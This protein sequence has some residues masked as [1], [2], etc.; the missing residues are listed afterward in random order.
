[1]LDL[2]GGRLPIQTVPRAGNDVESSAHVLPAAE[3]LERN[4]LVTWEVFS[5]GAI[6]E[7]STGGTFEHWIIERGFQLA[8][9]DR[10]YGYGAAAVYHHAR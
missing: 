2:A 4:G 6:L 7:K 9:H 1:M 8:L 10:G 3:P 5:G